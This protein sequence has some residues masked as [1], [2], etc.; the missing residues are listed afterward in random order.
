MMTPFNNK[1]KDN[2]AYRT[3][4]NGFIRSDEVRVI[5]NDGAML[6]VMALTAAL[7]L[8]QE[9]GLDLIEINSKTAPIIVRIA[10]F[11]KFQYEQKKQQKADKK[12]QKQPEQKLIELRPTTDTN[13]INHKLDKIKELLALG[14]RIKICVKFRGREMSFRQLGQDKL[15]SILE[16][17]TDLISG[18]TPISME[19]RDMSSIVSPKSTKQ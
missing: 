19:G 8:A 9:Q 2:A 15:T 10:N 13:D 14:H 7:A 1:E 11:D 3:R 5:A 18:S 12:K 17:L 4:I 6:G 16:Q